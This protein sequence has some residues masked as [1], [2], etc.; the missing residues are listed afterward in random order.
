MLLVLAL[1]HLTQTCPPLAL[2]SYRVD[3]NEEGAVADGGDDL[4]LIVDGNG[5]LKLIVDVTIG[6]GGDNKKGE[7]AVDVNDDDGD[8]MSREQP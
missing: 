8:A 2:R 7:W 4:E 3:R 6:N 5:D 1:P